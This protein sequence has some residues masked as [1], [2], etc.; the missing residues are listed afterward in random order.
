MKHLPSP[1]AIALALEAARREAEAEL[2]DPGGRVVA[3]FDR[4][5]CCEG[6][7]FVLVR[8]WPC[9]ICAGEGLVKLPDQP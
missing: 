7:G 9:V 2:Q 5:P 4:C 8:S 6:R 1:A 3:Y